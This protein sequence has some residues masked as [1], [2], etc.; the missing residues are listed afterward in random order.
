MQVTTMPAFFFKCL[1]SEYMNE[2]AQNKAACVEVIKLAETD[3]KCKD[4]QNIPHF[5]L[6]QDEGGVEWERAMVS[7]DST[8]P[9]DSED[10][11]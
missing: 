6:G 9:S 7:P 5:Q 4:D 8:N 1:L 3:K 11:C 2:W 10:A